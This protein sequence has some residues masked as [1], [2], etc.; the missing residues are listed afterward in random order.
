[1]R[2]QPIAINHIEVTLDNGVLLDI[3]DG[4]FARS[5][6]SMKISTQSD[7]YM[8]SVREER[9]NLSIRFI[10]PTDTPST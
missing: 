10:S 3:N 7:L 5:G 9:N 8:M 6:G 2:I 1:M 4:T